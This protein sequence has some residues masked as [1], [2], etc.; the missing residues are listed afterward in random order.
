MNEEKLE[1]FL[2]LL[3]M[4]GIEDPT[5]FYVQKELDYCLEQLHS[6]DLNEAAR[7]YV[8]AQAMRYKTWIN[9]ELLKDAERLKGK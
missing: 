1:E 2:E 4:S 5:V 9:Q 8:F 3:E 7:R 6:D